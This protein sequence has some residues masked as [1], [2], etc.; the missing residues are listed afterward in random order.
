[1][2]KT[3]S[4]KIRGA[5]AMLSERIETLY[6]LLKCN[7]T[8]IARFAG[9]SSGNISRLKSGNR[10]PVPQSRT[11]ALLVNGIYDYADYENLLPP[12]CELIG[13]SD[14][15]RENVTARL[16]AWLYETDEVT[17][18]P[19][20]ILPKSRRLK[21]LRLKSFG[22]RL[23][24][25]MTLLELSNGQLAEL[26]NIDPSLVS[27]YRS[28]IYS[29]YGNKT[30]SD[31]LSDILL[32][33]SE[34]KGK[35]AALKKLC[36][37]DEISASVLS[38][39]LYEPS[40]EDSTLF[41]QMLLGSLD[42][43]I[44]DK[45]LS[46]PGT[47]EPVIKI[48][49]LYWG[50]GGLRSAVSRFLSDAA[51]TGGELLLYSDEPMD[52]MT[53][54]RD[55]FALW[56]SLM[57]K[58]IK[59]GVHIKIIHNFDRDIMEMVAAIS[60]WFPLYITGMI[61]PYVFQ[62][63]RNTRFCYTSFL[64]SGTACIRGI[65][66]SGTDDQRFYDYIKDP[67]KL[68][69]LN[70]EYQTMLSSASPLLKTYTASMGGE[71]RFLRLKR[72]DA[73]NYLLQ[74]L[75]VFTMPEDLLLNILVRLDIPD[76]ERNEIHSAYRDLRRQFF[77]IIKIKQ[78]NLL[79]CLPPKDRRQ[80]NFSLDL[81]DLSSFYTYEE[82][83]RHIRAVRELV[84]TEKN[85]HLTLLPAAP[86]RDI[87]LITMG[88]AVSVLRCREPYAAFVF[89]DPVLTRSISDYFDTLIKQYA[90]SRTETTKE[91]GSSV[92]G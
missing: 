73:R 54:D 31:R 65:F 28:G 2:T 13:V 57:M 85:F 24:L 60:G 77:E 91:L 40:E 55:Y 52:W 12:L 25:A 64:H 29:P 67:K 70:A 75:P 84:E 69:A 38:G 15:N 81:V 48:D 72:T 23:D 4:L 80:I 14:A 63:E 1:M 56:A 41:A 33:Q 47:P 89:T 74:A 50:T 11:I 6:K 87:Q 43:F 7:N 37:T 9:C 46:E 21:E 10:V 30:L 22:N 32:W 27:R 58:C 5:K 68:K 44:P 61:E 76:T 83:T 45:R 35:T 92:C 82:Y 19:K 26:L 42:S 79:I 36:G 49:E 3:N 62:K 34:K 39:W 17:L 90:V 66:P 59:S 16:A 8:D 51:K 18:P 71:F 88:D 86:F 53:E 78:V 20:D